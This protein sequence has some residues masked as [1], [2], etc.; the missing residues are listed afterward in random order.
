MYYISY[1]ETLSI[2]IK[3]FDSMYIPELLS[4]KSHE[5]KCITAWEYGITTLIL[6]YWNI[7]STMANLYV[8]YFF[9]ISCSILFPV[10]IL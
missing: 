9:V 5:E 4:Q 1:S 10:M 3:Y 7:N 8:D 2:S 6:H